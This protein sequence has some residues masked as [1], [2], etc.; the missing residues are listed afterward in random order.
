MFIGIPKIEA[1]A[2]GGLKLALFLRGVREGVLAE[3]ED[4]GGGCVVV[5]ANVPILEKSL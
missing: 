2:T 4:W 1:I 5:N 3:A